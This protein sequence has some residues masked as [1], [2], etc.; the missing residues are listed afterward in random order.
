MTLNCIGTVGAMKYISEGPC[1]V[2]YTVLTTSPKGPEC[3][4]SPLVPAGPWN[5]QIFILC[6]NSKPTVGTEVE[7][8]Y[9]LFTVRFTTILLQPH[10]F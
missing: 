2:T 6:V 10:H 7:N 9:R 4:F 8:N 5:M 3:P 1:Y